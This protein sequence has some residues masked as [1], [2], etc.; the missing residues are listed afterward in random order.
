MTLIQAIARVMRATGIIRGDTDAPTTLSDLQH[1][2]T[3]NLA[4]IAIQDE[5]NELTSDM[6][7]AYEHDAT[8]IVS[9]V[10]GTRSYSLASDFVRFFGEGSLYNSGDNVH[11]FE[12]PGGEAKLQQIYPNYKTAQG[13]PQFWYF[14]LTTSKKVAL[15]PVPSVDK[16][17]TYDYEQDVSVSA[18]A[19]TMPFHNEQE[20]QAF[21]RLASRRFKFLYEGMDP[22]LIAADPEHMKAKATLVAMMAG[23]NPARHYGPVYR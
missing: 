20:A 7:I 17:Y 8:G 3:I 4:V 21:C 18:A 19:D 13:N 12:F 11:I 9:A 1:G 23:K 22:A 5:L 6:L 10:A 14:D 16:T 15:W 2:A